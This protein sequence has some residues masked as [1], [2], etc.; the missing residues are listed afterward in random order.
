MRRAKRLVAIALTSALVLVTAA[1]PALAINDG[2]VPAEECS[3]NPTA[4]G[5]P[6]GG[7]NPGLA[8]S[9]PVGPP[10]SANNP[11][12]SQGAQGEERSQAE[13]HC[14]NAA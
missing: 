10:A 4:V 9:E 5:T 14:P 11:G 7:P 12:Q 1:F 6:Q 3:D 8:V 2:R 13:A